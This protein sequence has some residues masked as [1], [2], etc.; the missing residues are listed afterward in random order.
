MQ[1]HGHLFAKSRAEFAGGATLLNGGLSDSA[2]WRDHNPWGFLAN[3]I[4]N[5]RGVQQGFQFGPEDAQKITEFLVQDANAQIAVISGAWAVPLFLAQGDFEETRQK[6][7]RLQ[8][9]EATFLKALRARD[10]KARVWIWTMADFVEAPQ[11]NL[12][13]LLDAVG[14]AAQGHPKEMPKM[15]NLEGFGHFLQDL[16]NQGMHPYL[17]GDFSVGQKP[18]P[19]IPDKRKPYLVR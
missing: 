2:H 4:W 1:V 15:A 8:G 17:M 10:V 16:K 19:Q 18:A 12:Q 3:L 6:A 11:E 14:G 13:A 9:I 7:A 5:T